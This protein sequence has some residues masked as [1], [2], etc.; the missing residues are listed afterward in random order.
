MKAEDRILKAHIALMQ[1]KR[2]L[3]YSG[4]IM[5]GKT[6]IRGDI[7]TAA[8]NGRDVFYGREFVDSLTDQELRGL[9]LHEA[10]HKLYQHLFIWQKLFEEDH[11]LAGIACDFVINLEILDIDRGGSFISLPACG[12][13]DEQY[14]GMNTAEVYAKLKK[15]YGDKQSRASKGGGKLPKELDEHQWQDAA[16]LSPEE[17]EQLSR[18]LDGAVRTGALLAGKQGGDVDRS[19][20]ALMASKVDWREQLREFVSTT[21]AGKGDS[22]WAKPNR[23]WLSQDIYMPSQI[24]ETVG[25]MCVAIDTS[26]SINDEAITKALSEVVAICDNTTPEKVDLLYWDTQVASHEQYREDNYAGLVSSTKPKGG[27]GT[28]VGCVMQYIDDNK[29]KPECTIIITDGYTGFPKDHPTYPVIWVIVG[30]NNV[31]PPFGS[32]I[33]LEE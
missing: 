2:T 21:C 5:V 20:E 28:D 26:G 31:V 22:T 18:E 8:T 11:E 3:A 23:R 24:S 4:I 13:I 6:A 10:K 15:Q 32:V 9:V 1:D 33:R 30:G 19:F 14:R 12:C 16:S 29:L 27:G 7:D 17:K 25:S